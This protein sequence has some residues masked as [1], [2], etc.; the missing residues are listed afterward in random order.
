MQKVDPHR[1]EPLLGGNAHS[2]RYGETIHD[3]SGKPETVNHQEEAN[4]ENFVMG[5]DA[6]EF[7]N[8]VKD[9]VR[10]RQKRMS[11]VAE[12]SE[13]HSIIWG[14]FMATTL[15][16]ATFMGE[17]FSTI[18]SV[19]K[20]HEDLTLKQ[21]FD[22]TAQLLI[23]QDEINGLDK[24]LWE[25]YSW[26]R[27]SL[28]GDET[29]ISLQRTKVYVFSD[30]V[31]CLGKV[32]Q[33]PESNEAWKNRVAGVRSEKS[34]RDYDGLNGESTEFEWNIFRGFTTLQLCGK[35]ND[36]LSDL[37]QTPETFTGR[38]LFMSMFND[39]S[40]DRKG[41]KD[42]CLANAETVKVL[43]RRFGI[44][45]WSFIGPGSEK[46]WYS[47]E[48]SPQGAW[49]GIAEQMLLEFAESGHPTF[50][51]T[52]PLSRGILKSKGRGKLS[53][54]FA[55]DV[56]TV[57][58]IYRI[59]LSVNQ[60]SAYGAVTAICEEFESHQD[61][62]GEPEIL[63]GQS[64]VLGEVKAEA[65]LQNENP[66]K[67]QIIW[68]QYIQQVESLSPENKV[69][70]F[71]KEA[72]LTSVVEVGQYF[73]T[74]NT[75]NLT[76][77]RSVACR[78]YTLPRDDKASQPKGWILGNMRIGPVLEVTTSFQHFRYGIEIRIWSVNQDNSQSWARISYGTVKYVVDSI[79]DNTE[80]PA[81]PQEERVP[82]T[83]IKVVAARSKAK[84]KPQPRVLVG[85]AATIPIHE[86]RWIDIEPSE[87]NLASYDLSKKVV[88]LLRHNQ[89]LQREE[90]GAIEFYKIKFYLRNHH[91]QIQVWSDDRWKACLAA[92]GGSKRRYQ[93]CSDDSGKILYLRAL[94]GHSGS[95]LIDPTLQDNV[96]IGT[97]IFP[98]V[99]HI[100]CAFN[101]HSIINN[102]LILGGKDLSRRQTVFFLPTDP[103]DESHKDLE[104]IDF[105]VPRLARYVHSAWK[106][107]Q[108]A[109]F[110]VDIDLAIREGLTFYQTRSNAIILQG[111]LPAYCIVKVERLKTG[112]VLYERRYLSPRPPPKISLKHDHNWTKGNDQLGSTVEQQP[113]GKLAQ[114]C[115]GEAPRVKLSKPTQS[116]PN[117]ICDRSG[118]LE[119]TERVCVENGK[120]SRSQE[121][122]DKRLHKELGSSDRTGK[123]VKSEDNRVM[124]AHDGTGEPVKSSASTHTVEEFVPAEHRDTASSNANKFNLATDEENIDFNIPGVPNSMVKRSHGVDVHN[125]IQKFENQPQRQALQSDLQQHR[126]FNP[127]SRES[128]DAIKAAGN[129]ELC[130]IVDVEPKAQCR[131]CLTYW[132]VGIVFCT[133]GH[134]LKDDKTANKK[135]IKAVLDLFSIPNFYIR[136][137][138]PHGHRY[139]KKEGCKEYHTA[140]QLQKKCRK[141]EY[142]NIHDR[143]IRDLWFRKTMLELGRSE[144]VIL[145][146]DRLANEDHT[147]IATEEELDVYRG[148]WWIR[149]NF[150]GSDT[151]PV[152]HRPD[153]KKALST[154]HR[155]KKA[156]DKAY[157]QN[158]SQS[159]SS[160]WWQ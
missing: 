59:I 44:G 77:Y 154:L 107:H 12:S 56:D 23:N 131:A 121:I 95:N 14:M 85:T 96:V 38:I 61:R 26:T 135:Y 156:E 137:G 4:S 114:Q 27:L 112:E 78:E 63:M 160:S 120:T 40:C 87:Q 58:T 98:Y 140:N 39:I 72:G 53:I 31:L 29:V 82:Q 46:K 74:K 155:L 125:L 109:V 150:V 148:N 84:A 15:N 147:H 20:N 86:R 90:D 17:N 106:R 92:G 89:T 13:E 130:E 93:Y 139:G 8:K 111:T 75:G 136:K 10:N 36:L 128:Q 115:F 113:V 94:Q 35:I 48:N 2:A 33:H 73:V 108:D 141:K 124:H 105:S 7:V 49:D 71:C 123:L 127:F 67:D 65:L 68:Q 47:S 129:T 1:E 80:I 25:K 152:R 37:G 41:N 21:M 11:N 3:G 88:N 91:S 9:Q 101:L 158:W 116:K 126:P 28:I 60:L 83:S 22:I 119:V 159:S 133:C 157:Y 132:D 146:M 122:D 97:G 52:T 100:G 51:A 5:S 24:I 45:Q 142:K 30:S 18:Q 134:F 16:A 103:R 104:H 144:E 79:Q 32:L 99:Y 151:M 19:V 69:S 34:Y 118:K 6:A 50:R 70:K 64:I 149:S 62:S 55:A 138:R 143:F 54:H 42:E 57:G 117:P 81:D 110:W 76:Q 145:E 66:M 102:G 153:F 43:A